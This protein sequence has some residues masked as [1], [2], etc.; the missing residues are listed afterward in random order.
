MYANECIFYSTVY[1]ENSGMAFET[2]H[3]SHPV[4]LALR[5]SLLYCMPMKEILSELF[6]GSLLGILLQNYVGIGNFQRSAKE[7]FRSLCQQHS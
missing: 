3:Q 1:I 7:I 2:V 6:V 4:P 5:N